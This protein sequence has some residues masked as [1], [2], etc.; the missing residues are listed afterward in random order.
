MW[1][2]KHQKYSM[3]DIFQD[4]VDEKRKGIKIIYVWLNECKIC[5]NKIPVLDEEYSFEYKT[6]NESVTLAELL[7]ALKGFNQ[8]YSIYE[9]MYEE[10]LESFEYIRLDE[11]ENTQVYYYY[12][13]DYTTTELCNICENVF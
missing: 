2:I 1:K 6:E 11:Y 7:E 13:E 4:A 12:V 3:K 8:D 9:N 5:G 10:E